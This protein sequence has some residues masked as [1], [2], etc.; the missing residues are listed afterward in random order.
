MKV[1]RAQRLQGGVVH[2]LLQAAGVRRGHQNDAAKADGTRGFDLQGAADLVDDL[3]T[4]YQPLEITAGGRP[5]HGEIWC[6]RMWIAR[7][8]FI[9]QD[10]DSC[11]NMIYDMIY[12]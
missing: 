6:A 9:P 1:S 2:G 10:F 3:G 7:G 11:K 8:C 4:R 5:H 12:N